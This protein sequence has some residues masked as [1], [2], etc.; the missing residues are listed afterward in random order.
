M[1]NEKN[2]DGKF[3]L[4]FFLGGLLSTTLIFLFGTE[5]GKKTAKKLSKILGTLEDELKEKGG[6][7]LEDA[8]KVKKTMLKE[9]KEGKKNLSKVVSAKMDKALTTLE[10]VQRKGIKLTR[11]AH[12]RFFS[13]GGK[14]LT[15]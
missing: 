5:D 8:D 15:K 7:I 11:D 3:L 12:G 9:T 13:K 2:K 6:E 1:E 10:H 4:G 14:K